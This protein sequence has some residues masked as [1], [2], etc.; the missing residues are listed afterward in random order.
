MLFDDHDV[1]DDWNTSQAWVR[2]MRAKPWWEEHIAAALSSYFVYQHLGNLSPGALAASELLA[3]IRAADDAGPLLRDWACAAD[4]ET[5]G[6]RWSTA[7]DVGRTRLLMLDSR[8]GRV[9]TPDARR[10]VDDDEWAWIEEHARGDVDHLL[11]ADTLPVF[12]SPA[13]HHA[14]AFSEALAAGAWGGLVARVA[15]TRAAGV[16]PRALGGVQRLVPAD[17]RAR[18]GGVGGRAGRAARVDRAARRR[19]APRLRGAD[20]TPAA[21]SAV[22]QAVCSPMRNPLRAHRAAAGRAGLLGPP[23]TRRARAGARRRRAR[24]RRWT[25]RSPTARRSTTRS[26]R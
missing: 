15:E 3:R 25:G 20:R 4:A 26:R 1:H 16:R 19:R 11:L 23:G 17:V 18:D 2:E 21:R 9:L 22:W 24:T 10:M 7:R 13:F 14:E 6:S 8:E 5:D 12:F